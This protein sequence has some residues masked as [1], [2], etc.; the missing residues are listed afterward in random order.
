MMA[1]AL[2]A[3]A[4]PFARSPVVARPPDRPETCTNQTIS[5]RIMG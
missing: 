5:T 3:L 2:G 1:C 4:R